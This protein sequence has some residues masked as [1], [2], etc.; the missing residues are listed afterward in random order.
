MSRLRPDCPRDLD[1]ILLRA[2][3]RDPNDRHASAQ[4]LQ[5]DLEESLAMRP[6]VDVGAWARTLVDAPKVVELAP[7]LINDRTLQMV[8]TEQLPTTDVDTDDF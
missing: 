2:A 1:A 3:A 7:D 8:K 5:L 6:A 4:E